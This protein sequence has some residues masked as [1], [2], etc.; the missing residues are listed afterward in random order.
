[1]AVICS[2]R[3]DLLLC[4]PLLVYIGTWEIGHVGMHSHVICTL[5]TSPP[6]ENHHLHP[7]LRLWIPGLLVDWGA[8]PRQEI[9]R[10]G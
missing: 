9:F 5:T 2:N 1:M 6:P 3:S 4:R 7:V 10:A 8:W